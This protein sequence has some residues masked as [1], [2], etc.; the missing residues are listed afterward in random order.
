[1]PASAEYRN[2]AAHRSA[3]AQPSTT[4]LNCSSRTP[5]QPLRNTTKRKMSRIVRPSQGAQKT[6]SSSNR[7]NRF[8][9]GCSGISNRSVKYRRTR[10]SHSSDCLLYTSDAADEE[11]S[12]DLGGRRI[13]KK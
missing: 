3:A 8:Q 11:D 13:I 12:V 6:G 9:A 10:L 4:G 2:A 7:R 5:Y 1:M